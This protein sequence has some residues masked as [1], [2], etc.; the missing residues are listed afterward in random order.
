MLLRL[1]TGYS[2]YLFRQYNDEAD[3]SRWKTTEHLNTTSVNIFH[4]SHIWISV[5]AFWMPDVQYLYSSK[6]WKGSQKICRLR[7]VFNLRL[8]SFKLKYRIFVGNWRYN[9]VC[10]FYVREVFCFSYPKGGMIFNVPEKMLPKIFRYRGGKVV[11]GG[12]AGGGRNWKMRNLI[13]FFYLRQVTSVKNKGKWNKE[14]ME[15][16]RKKYE[17]NFG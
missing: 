3:N 4:A 6:K 10:S 11:G 1:N 9:V 12:G 14:K 8:F 2:C 16:T 13:V 5:T 17:Q 15:G 7:S